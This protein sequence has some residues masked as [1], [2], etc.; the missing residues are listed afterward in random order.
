MTL[1]RFAVVRT[2]NMMGTKIGSFLV[3]LR[4]PAEIENGNILAIGALE[5]ESREVREATVPGAATPIGELA[6]IASEEIVKDARNNKHDI[7]E[8]INEANTT[9][10]GYR[11]APNDIFS[12]S[13][14]ALHASSPAPAVGQFAC[15]NADSKIRLA[16]ASTGT[17]VG[18]V[19]AVEME[20]NGDEWIVIQVQ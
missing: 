8:F 11:L 17:V 19:I 20:S 14:K 3:S 9:L 13:P 10:R 2:D 18:K 12:V 4:Y 1:K 5:D 15:V 7:F 6:L 16:A